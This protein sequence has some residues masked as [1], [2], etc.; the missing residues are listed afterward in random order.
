MRFISIFKP[1]TPQRNDVTITELYIVLHNICVFYTFYLFQAFLAASHLESIVSHHEI[2]N[3]GSDDIVIHTQL[4]EEI[5][6]TNIAY[7]RI[8]L[9]KRINKICIVKVYLVNFSNV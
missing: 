2:R 8:F 4:V 3:G 1:E 6:L 5:C 9:S 7:I